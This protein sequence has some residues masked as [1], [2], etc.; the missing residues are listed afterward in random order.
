MKKIISAVILLAL[1]IPQNSYGQ[2]KKGF[3]FRGIQLGVDLNQQIK[4]C[5]E[6]L[7]IKNQGFDCR[8]KCGPKEKERGEKRERERMETLGRYYTPESP[9][10]STKDCGVYN[11]VCEEKCFSISLVMPSPVQ[12]GFDFASITD[13]P[14][15][16]I[17]VNTYVYLYEGK[18]EKIE[19]SF[20]WM[21]SGKYLELLTAKYGKPKTSVTI[22]KNRMNAKFRNV[23]SRWVKGDVT[24]YF[25]SRCGEV[26]QACLTIES[27]KFREAA[28]KETIKAQ[29]KNADRL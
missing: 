2:E 4:D 23:E 26:D 29:K 20:G 16:G 12:S 18:V 24:I 28:K 17:G 27:K 22:V 9:L 10:T 25:S 6:N 7:K 21:W 13:L 14:K 11:E 19:E 3:S 5:N 15:I 1:I 8:Y